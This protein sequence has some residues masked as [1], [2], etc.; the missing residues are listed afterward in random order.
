[1]YKNITYPPVTTGGIP[2]LRPLEVRYVLKVHV[3]R[4]K[5]P[6][7]IFLGSIKICFHFLSHLIHQS[8]AEEVQAIPYGS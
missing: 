1:M 7:H 2:T 8:T 5:F 6:P 3:I 4:F